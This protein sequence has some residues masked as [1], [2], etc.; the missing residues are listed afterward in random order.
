V[1]AG[2]GAEATVLTAREEV[3]AGT[4]GALAAT[5]AAGA[6]GAFGGINNLSAGLA[7]MTAGAGAGAITLGTAATSLGVVGAAPK[8][9]AAV[10]LDGEERGGAIITVSTTNAAANPPASA[11]RG[12]RGPSHPHND[13]RR[14]GAAV[15][16]R[17]RLTSSCNSL[18][19]AACNSN[20]GSP[21][22]R[23]CCA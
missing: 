4:P 17:E 5:M 12:H 6:G 23:R 13:W 16:P 7:G 9:G 20:G 21:C 14:P 1:A 15:P 11:S 10:W 19:E 2:S 18:R 22:W 8:A 3:S